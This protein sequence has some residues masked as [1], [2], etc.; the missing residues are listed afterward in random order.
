MIV[1]FGGVALG[2]ALTA[3]LARSNER[4]A[5]RDEPLADAANDAIDAIAEVA[6][7]TSREAL[8]HYASAVSRVALHGSPEV[9]ATWRCFQADATSKTDDGRRRL[10]AAVQAVRS[11]LGH[12]AAT[13]ADLYVLMFGQGRPRPARDEIAPRQARA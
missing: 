5:R 4:R 2:T 3:L 6:A 12:G 10:V 1:G 13:D 9:I 7:G 11:Q 8:A